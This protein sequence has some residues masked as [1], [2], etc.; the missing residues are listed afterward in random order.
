MALR[1]KFLALSPKAPP[2]S[3]PL[4]PTQDSDMDTPCRSKVVFS[5]ILKEV[6]T[7]GYSV[8]TKARLEH[9]YVDR[10][11]ILSIRII[12]LIKT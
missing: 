4:N 5:P 7:E 10:G 2:P 11:I 3:A 1:E 9:S 8:F 6:Y 12:K